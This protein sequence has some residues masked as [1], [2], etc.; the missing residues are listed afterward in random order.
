MILDFPHAMASSSRIMSTVERSRW[1]RADL[2][3]VHENLASDS[4]KYTEVALNVRCTQ[5]HNATFYFVTLPLRIQSNLFNP[6]AL[7]L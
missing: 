7:G 3:I 5:N 6:P 2:K 4:D 1:A